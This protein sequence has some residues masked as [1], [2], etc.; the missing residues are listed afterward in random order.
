MGE[1][2]RATQITFMTFRRSVTTQTSAVLTKSL[3]CTI[4]PTGWSSPTIWL[5]SLMLRLCTPTLLVVLSLMPTNL[6]PI[7]FD[8]LNDIEMHMPGV[9]LMK[10][11]FDPVASEGNN[12]KRREYRNCQ[13]MTPETWNTT[14]FYWNYLHNFDLDNTATTR[15][16][17][18]SLLEGFMEDKIYIEEQQK[19]L[20]ETPGF[21]P[22]AIAGDKALTVFRNKW[23]QWLR[24]EAGEGAQIVNTRTLI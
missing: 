16:L 12:T 15:S 7:K 22:R 3:I 18:E 1:A 8:R 5:I 9:F 6:C 2:E 23:Q 10:T 11:P 14:H 17:Q 13:F 24:D 4:R 21:V 20:E 19:L